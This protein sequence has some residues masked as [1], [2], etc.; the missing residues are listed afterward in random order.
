MDV[1]LAGARERAEQL[2]PAAPV[3][4]VEEDELPHVAAREHP[5]RETALLGPF[6]AGLERC[7]LGADGGDLV[8]VRKAL[9][10]RRPHGSLTIAQAC[11]PPAGVS[12]SSTTSKPCPA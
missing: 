6:G 11:G 8:A 10:R 3:D 12:P 5:A 2:D 9:R 7:G 4:E 1:D